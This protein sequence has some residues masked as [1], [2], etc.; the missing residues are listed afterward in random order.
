M[1]LKHY[2]AA[3]EI[4]DQGISTEQKIVQELR[5]T[6]AKLLNFQTHHEE[7]WSSHLDALAEAKVLKDN[8]NLQYDSIKHIKG[9]CKEKIIK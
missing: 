9:E 8:P 1:T 5:N 6:T 2:R 7:V 4:Y 3:A